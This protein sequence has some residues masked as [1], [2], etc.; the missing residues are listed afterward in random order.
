M[1]NLRIT[2]GFDKLSESEL[3]TRARSIL[4]AMTSNAAFP[5]PK[6]TLPEMLTAI[7]DYTEALALAEEG[8]SNDKALKDL[9]KTELID[10]L[11]QLGNYVL[12]QSAGNFYTAQSS[13]FNIAKTSRTPAPDVTSATGQTLADGPNKGELDFRFKPVPGAKSYV[14]Q[15]TVGDI[16][17]NSVWQSQGGT[18]SRTRFSGLPSG[19]RVWCRVMAI[20]RNGQ[21]V[22]SEPIS[23]IVQ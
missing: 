8:S 1:T 11:H 16:T 15:W 21:M 2:N 19:Q 13:K 4:S 20:G 18:V 3:E 23:R 5:T 9:K 6:P 10:M 22:Y 12:Y 14:Y 7:N 17:E